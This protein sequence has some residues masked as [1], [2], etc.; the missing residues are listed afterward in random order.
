MIN[1]TYG[2]KQHVA[3]WC[4]NDVYTMGINW[5]KNVNWIILTMDK[6]IALAIS[7]TDIVSTLLHLCDVTT[8]TCECYCD[9]GGPQVSTSVHLS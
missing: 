1:P 7:V 4:D 9:Y 6:C 3:F 2:I 8:N 5:K